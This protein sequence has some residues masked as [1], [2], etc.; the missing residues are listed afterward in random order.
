M[1][2]YVGTS[3]Y[4]YDEWKGS[5]YPEDLS[6]KRMLSYYGERLNAVEINNTFYRLPKGSVLEN[7]ASQ[8]PEAFRFSIKA[9]RRITH[10]ARLKPEARDP[11]EYMMSTVGS[12]GARLGVVLFQLP[13]NLKAD[14]ERLA[15]FLDTLP[16]GAPGAFEFRHETW[17]DAAV[18]DVLRAR[19]MALVCADTEDSTED[20]PI[21]STT[22]WGYLRLR[23]PDYGDDDLARW[24]KRVAGSGW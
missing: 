13:P 18:H 17:Q 3:G 22:S 11:T 16:A 19:G 9:S 23:R 24:A 6:A 12:L 2:L 7:W 14:V 15:A 5:F 21:I 10:F 20:E 4:S 1:E 8:V